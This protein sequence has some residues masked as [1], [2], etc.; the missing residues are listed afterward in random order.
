MFSL[1]NWAFQAVKYSTVKKL[2]ITQAVF[3]PLM[4]EYNNAM[5]H[6]IPKSK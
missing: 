2:I 4:K 6:I 5:T 1:L 3:S